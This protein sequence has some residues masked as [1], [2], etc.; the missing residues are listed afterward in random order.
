MP[1][2]ITPELLQLRQRDHDMHRVL[3]VALKPWQT[4]AGMKALIDFGTNRT[5]FETYFRADY[6]CK[7]HHDDV[8]YR[9]EARRSAV[10]QAER[11]GSGAIASIVEMGKLFYERK[12]PRTIADLN[13]GLASGSSSSLSATAL[14]TLPSSSGRSICTWDAENA[15]WFCTSERSKTG[16]L[17]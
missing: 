2:N 4:L 1:Q 5:L 13:Y 9:L 11:A 15:V 3:K 17:F 6:F 8:E 14:D 16:K 12:A 10:D 7:Y